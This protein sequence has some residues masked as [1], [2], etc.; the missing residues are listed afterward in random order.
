MP[1]LGPSDDTKPGKL[2]ICGLSFALERL[3]KKLGGARID[4]I[5]EATTSCCSRFRRAVVSHKTSDCIYSSSKQAASS[6]STAASSSHRTHVLREQLLVV[7]AAGHGAGAAPRRHAAAAG[8]AR[9]EATVP[10]VPSPIGAADQLRDQQDVRDL[11]IVNQRL[12]DAIAS[13]DKLTYSVLVDDGVHD[14]RARWPAATWSRARPS[15]QGILFELEASRMDGTRPRRNNRRAALPRLRRTPRVVTY[16]EPQLPRTPHDA[17]RGD[18]GL[19]NVRSRLG[20]EPA[21]APRALPPVRRRRGDGRGALRAC[22]AP[23]AN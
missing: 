6:S 8:A 19:E 13:G 11:E 22:A 10:A 20:R 15:R 4:H 9:A 23:L 17:D 1:S 7:P 14:L 2:A 18:A 3:C 16:V 21:L 12:L 5:F